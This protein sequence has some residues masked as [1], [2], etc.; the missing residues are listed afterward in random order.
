MRPVCALF[1]IIIIGTLS[2]ARLA[3]AEEI[4]LRLIDVR[5]GG[6]EKNCYVMLSG[7]P[8][9]GP[10]QLH[11][12]RIMRGADIEQAGDMPKTPADGRVRFNITEALP[13]FIMADVGLLECRPCDRS[14]DLFSADEILRTGVMGDVSGGDE[15]SANACRPNL[16]KLAQIK[17]KPGE[18]VIFVRKSTFGERWFYYH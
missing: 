15:K 5:S 1:L 9:G 17:A 13:K 18:I 14:R 10:G 7:G 4:V 11:W 8:G 12:L 6:G 3:F 16:N 2:S